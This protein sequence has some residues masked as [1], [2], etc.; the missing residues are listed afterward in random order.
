MKAYEL[1][2][3][4]WVFD[5]MDKQNIELSLDDFQ[6]MNN[7]VRSNH[8]IPYKAISLSTEWLK[9]FQF[10]KKEERYFKDF[11]GGSISINDEGECVLFVGDDYTLNV[12]MD[13]KCCTLPVEIKHLHQ[14]QNLYFALTGEE[15]NIN[16]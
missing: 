8:P 5:I 12:A 2:L 16:L 4:N 1:R 11:K 7:F 3:G 13:Y 6:C 10:V 14:L 9:K 15:L